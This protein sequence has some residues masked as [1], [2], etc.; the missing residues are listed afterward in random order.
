MKEKVQLRKIKEA[1]KALL[2]RK[3]KNAVNKLVK[4]K[5]GKYKMEEQYEKRKKSR[6]EITVVGIKKR[7]LDPGQWLKT[8]SE[9]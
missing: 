7:S 8:T 5:N 9:R 2:S 4:V 3:H 1:N 6:G